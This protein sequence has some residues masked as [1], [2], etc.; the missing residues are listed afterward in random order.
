MFVLQLVC[1]GPFFSPLTAQHQPCSLRP[2]YTRC[3][4]RQRPLVL[5]P[6]LLWDQPGALF[7]CALALPK[8]VLKAASASVLEVGE[9]PQKGVG[10][11]VADG[12]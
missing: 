2:A 10:H 1:Q 7:L 8:T 5:Q 6:V 11:V 4:S 9:D 12:E 3:G